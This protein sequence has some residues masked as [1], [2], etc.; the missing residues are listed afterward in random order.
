MKHLFET[1]GRGCIFKQSCCSIT[2]QQKG[3]K[4]LLNHVPSSPQLGQNA[5]STFASL[6]LCAAGEQFKMVLSFYFVPGLYPV[7]IIS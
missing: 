7:D 3:V 6:E 1:F 5:A 4:G 2:M